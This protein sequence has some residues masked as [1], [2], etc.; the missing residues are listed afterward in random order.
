MLLIPCRYCGPRE[1][2]E[3]V[4]G[5]SAIK[6]P[7]MDASASLKSWHEVIHLRENP[8]GL[9]LELWYHDAGCECWMEVI[10][11]TSTHLITEVRLAG[12]NQSTFESMMQ[13]DAN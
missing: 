9:L 3:F 13:P 7:V 11:N 2:S 8:A 10:R 12:D 4:Y 6:F 5:G 1:E